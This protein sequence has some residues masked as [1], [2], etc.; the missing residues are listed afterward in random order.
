[1]LGGIWRIVEGIF[2]GF[3]QIFNLPAYFE[4]FSKF[5]NSFTFIDWV[6]SIIAFILVFAIWALIIFAIVLAIRK[7]IR[8]RRSLVT[9][10]DLLEELAEEM[11]ISDCDPVFALNVLTDRESLA[12]ALGDYE[13]AYRALLQKNALLEAFQK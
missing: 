13:A 1:M 11:Q 9:S 5:S 3:I 10:E 4:Q 2:H 7:Y 6:L 12:G 8:F